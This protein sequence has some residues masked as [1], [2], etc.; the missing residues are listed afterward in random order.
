MRSICDIKETPE[1]TALVDGLRDKLGTAA[2]WEAAKDYLEHGGVVRTSAEV[3]EKLGHDKVFS[4]YADILETS[5]PQSQEDLDKMDLDQFKKLVK[6]NSKQ[7]S[8]LQIALVSKRVKAANG[9]LGRS[10]YIKFNQVGQSDI[11]TWTITERGRPL[12][13]LKEELPAVGRKDFT[14]YDTDNVRAREIVLKMAKKLEG[15]TGIP[16][17]I[18][19]RK[20]AH[21]IVTAA[22]SNLSFGSSAFFLNG[23]SY[24]ISNRL[25]AKAVLHEYSHPILRSIAQN[26]N[27]LFEKLYKDLAA[28]N[29]GATLIEAVRAEYPE[30]LQDEQYDRFFKEEVLAH[31]L[32]VAHQ[33][34]LDDVA[35]P[36]GFAKVLKDLLYAIKQVLRKV[37]GQKVEVSKLNPNTTL[38]NLADMLAK[39][40]EF[41]INVEEISQDDVTSYLKDQEN[42]AKQ[43]SDK[44]NVADIQSLVNKA[45]DMVSKQITHL[46]KNNLDEVADLFHNEFKSGDYDIIKKRLKNYQNIIKDKLV[47][48]KDDV[49]FNHERVNALLDTISTLDHTTAHIHEALLDLTRNLD[50]KDNLQQID[51]YKR[52][53]NYWEGFIKDAQS[54]LSTK[55]APSNPLAQLIGKIRASIQ[56]SNTLMDNVYDGVALNAL[57]DVHKET[58]SAMQEASAERMKVLQ[59]EL[60]KQTT[61]AG[62]ARVQTA[63]DSQIKDDKES[64]PT[65][66][67][68][69][70]ALRGQ[71]KDASQIQ[72]FVRSYLYNPDVVVGG[73]SKYVKDNMTDVLLKSYNQANEF[74][75]TMK[76][77]IDAA[78]GKSVSEGQLGRDIGQEEEFGSTD[79]EGK[80]V[81]KKKW[82]FLN[83]F[84]GAGVVKDEYVHKIREAQK[85]FS[86]T[87]SKDD[88][89]ALYDIQAEWR[90][91][92]R[93][94]WH[95][96]Y[97][98]DF[99]N[100]YQLLERDEVGKKAM[101]QMDDIYDKIDLALAPGT[102]ASEEEVE[103]KVEELYRELR[104]LSDFKDEAG[105]PK[106]KEALAIAK[107][108]K[109]F[110]ELSGAFYD[111]VE[112]PGAFDRALKAYEQRLMDEGKNRGTD[113]Y[114][115]LKQ[116]WIDRNTRVVIKPG[117]YE[118]R[119]LITDR[120]KEIM[121]HLPQNE[122]VELDI[123]K[124][125]DEI[126]EG[127][128]GYRDQ[129][130]QPIGSEMMQ[131]RINKI[132]A[133]Q[134]R[135]QE[136]RDRLAQA[137]GLTKAEQY[138]LNE[139][140]AKIFEGSDNNADRARLQ[141]LMARKSSLRLDKFQRA[142]LSSLYAKLSEL[143]KRVPTDYY[144]DTVN[145]W[146]STLE[147]DVLFNAYKI[148]SITKNT[149]NFLLEPGLLQNLFEQSPAF[150]D[151]FK[152]NHILKT[153]F[154]N[155]AGVEVER[156]ERVFVWNVT[157]PVD[158]VYYE[159]TTVENE[160]G[161]RDV[162]EGIPTLKY[163]KRLV[164]DEYKT[165]KVVGKTV[166]NR[167]HWLPKSMQDGAKDDRY[168]N[169]A[170]YNLQKNKPAMF[171][172]LE[173]MKKFHIQYQE[174]KEDKS[175]LWLDMPRFR[176]QSL[177][178]LQSKNLLDRLIQKVK[179]F[180]TKVN[181]SYDQGFNYDANNQMVQWDMFDSETAGIPI[182]GISNLDFD[183]VSTDIAY[184]M[185]RYMQSME[186]QQKLID[187]SPV[188]RA[189]QRTINNE[190]NTPFEQQMTKNSSIIY[191]K[192]KKKKYIRAQAV[193]RYIA[194][195]FEGEV[196]AGIGADSVAAQNV[197]G[198]L[199]K[200]ASFAYLAMNI[201][202][203]IK[204]AMSM[205]FQG[206]IYSAAGEN[207][208]AA[209]FLKAEG[210]ATQTA[211][212]ISSELY[213][214]GSKSF[215]TQLAD[216]FDWEQ[217][218]SE[219]LLGQS[220][221]RTAMKDTLKIADRLSDFRR[222]VQLQAT[223]QTGF[224]MMNH[225]K[226]EVDGQFIPYMDMWEVKEGKLQLKDGMPAE[227]GI[228]YD[229]AGNQIVGEKFK[230]QRNKM[231]TV[232]AKLNGGMSRA[233][234][235]ES[236]RYLAFRFISFLRR[237]FIEQFYNRFG[238]TQSNYQLGGQEQGMYTASLS[239]IWKM[240]KSG[241]AYMPIATTGEKR[242][243]IRSATEAG[244]LYLLTI[245]MGLMFD[246]DPE[247]KDRFA[248]LRAKTGFGGWIHNEA[249]LIMMQTKGENQQFIPLPG[250]GLDDYKSYLDIK[251]LAF[252][253]T[254]TAMMNVA[255]DGKLAV[256]GD[257]RL[258]YKR[259]V[260]GMVWQEKGSNKVWNHLFK[261]VGI[262][263]N[264]FHPD[265]AV[266]NYIAAQN[267]H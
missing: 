142:E 59:K 76:P 179:D 230:A 241:G 227:W 166:D 184:T 250:L 206:L 5:R 222:W 233:E 75:N 26:N 46:E 79:A 200:Q 205:K 8:G 170:Y 71:G 253:P 119:Q 186:R 144:V 115:I 150:E 78:G 129:D 257:D 94:F 63:I 127:T 232:M 207:M 190:E 50:D 259:T 30:L 68:I 3:L 60:A 267:L 265:I 43:L 157:R 237:W 110:R 164:K 134:Q 32:Q 228:T 2:E 123:T 21:D 216:V 220:L 136:S 58:V 221:T 210:I 125:W 99:N 159:T 149:S 247:D 42:I 67:K 255:N 140:F 83:E 16:Y 95:S 17:A 66:E 196:N 77:L 183:E 225:K 229:K 109:E 27:S 92:Q 231:Q 132:K 182:S 219:V 61:D 235:P 36:T 84:T 213:K 223:L 38:D 10:Y 112:V 195:E 188:V 24:F 249:L 248:K 103:T 52:V 262:S 124:A 209:E 56:A 25:S 156:W 98:T 208:S 29:E 14:T 148:N 234:S 202:S 117:F 147:T 126:L 264:T 238:K 7:V 176:K 51:Y 258:Y 54:N 218:R 12:T 141:E 18:V 211:F 145:A 62:K 82:Q 31:A 33:N 256:T 198:F 244:S 187:I 120:I 153:V 90:Q 173:R 40:S 261:M 137:S 167:G 55:V 266:R 91:H 252:A 116:Q 192:G 226:I 96:K 163:Y 49:A 212:E 215:H 217:G 185:M 177:E 97:T 172:V 57:D 193:N 48:I 203:A 105:R 81:K 138:E 86:E 260:G 122:Q 35:E 204:N 113:A 1:Y 197:S 107:R 263:G 143:Q 108:L 34:H 131:E 11:H 106:V 114:K 104:R 146:L 80:F 161:S 165:K 47:T 118:E 240:L 73:L 135:I 158:K 246:W 72:S 180:W 194:K 245:L 168:Q 15:Q 85:K 242:A 101:Q 53:L 111:T 236:D 64:I 162:I 93:D 6:L 128:K 121:S 160:D 87:N 151:W 181:D 89:Q 100:M 254:I 201:P 65:R 133:A 175:K 22:G 9:K 44:G 37:F 214:E 23:T 178:R 88:E 224:A 239:L 19:T 102:G 13:S 174:G 155:E 28:T 169:Q 74:G 70:E 251:S 69:V 191:Q 39:G 45:F 243:F 130:G 20:E 41:D 154:D 171:A 189:I 152:A 139:L 4:P 199:F